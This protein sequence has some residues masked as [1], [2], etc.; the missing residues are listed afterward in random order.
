MRSTIPRHLIVYEVIK[1]M[2][3]VKTARKC[4]CKE[5]LSSLFCQRNSDDLTTAVCRVSSFMATTTLSMC[6]EKPFPFYTKS[7]RNFKLDFFPDIK[8]H[9]TTSKE[10]GKKT[11]NYR[12]KNLSLASFINCPKLWMIFL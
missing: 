8:A 1:P 5:L 9:Q 4:Y 3:L 10:D 12:G 7:F 11:L 2:T 6:V